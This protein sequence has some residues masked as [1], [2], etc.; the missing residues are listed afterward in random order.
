MCVS[1][2]VSLCVCVCVCVC[3]STCVCVCVCVCAFLR[4]G[5]CVCAFLRNGVCVPGQ[6]FVCGY[7]LRSSRLLKQVAVGVEH[8]FY[9]K[10][11]DKG[12]T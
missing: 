3:V 11:H 7:H 4:N 9:L 1:V 2:C 8:I 6:L 10:P 5:V 12:I